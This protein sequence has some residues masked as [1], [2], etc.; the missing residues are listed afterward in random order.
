MPL[1]SLASYAQ[2][3]FW[4]FAGFALHVTYLT[5]FYHRRGFDD[6]TIGVLEAVG[7]LCVIVS[8]LVWGPLA[9]RLGRK[10]R[11]VARL[12]L[13][14]AICFPLLWVMP[15]RVWALI[16]VVVV[17]YLCR[18]PLIPLIDT[19]FL[20]ALHARGDSDG[21]T[22]GRVRLWGSLGFMVAATIIPLLLADEQTSDPLRRLFPVF[23]A[24]SLTSL[25]LSVRAMHMPETHGEAHEPL[26]GG[27][28]R[29]V[30]ALP[31]YKWLLALL[32]VSWIANQSYYLFLSLYLQSIGVSDRLKG[33]YWSMGVLA[34][35]AMLA[36]AP[37]LLSRVSLRTLMLWGFAGRLIRLTAFCFPL[38]PMVVLWCFQPLHALGFA[39]VHLATMGYLSRLV[40]LPLRATGQTL[41]AGLVT[42]VGGVL[43]NLLAGRI[44]KV[45]TGG[46]GLLGLHGIHA[47]YGAAAIIQL[48]VL[49]LAWATLREPPSA[50]MGGVKPEGQTVDES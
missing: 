49:L 13:G 11:L 17:F 35:V 34:E 36:A 9:D 3:Y 44:S 10:G 27:H 30:L 14:L 42:G 43:G 6:W 16:P 47:A 12:S 25:L 48:A 28:V 39:A 8:A 38:S 45:T 2:L 15:A 7:S 5:L 24:F 46:P 19:F 50:P 21:R 33:A 20:D 26:D 41:N 29:A 22:Y 37:W 1:T 18:S 31:S 4:L 32:L 23:I 40:P